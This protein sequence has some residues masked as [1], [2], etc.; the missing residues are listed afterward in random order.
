MSTFWHIMDVLENI[1]NTATVDNLL[2][3]WFIQSLYIQPELMTYMMVWCIYTEVQ[4]VVAP[5]RLM[6]RKDL[7]WQKLFGLIFLFEKDRILSVLTEI[8]WRQNFFQNRL[9]SEYPNYSMLKLFYHS[10]INSHIK[11]SKTLTSSTFMATFSKKLV[12]FRFMRQERKISFAGL[13]I[14]P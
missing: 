9:K 6:P 10:T 11:L 7:S 8:I 1:Y 3:V 12:E 2:D 4:K 13:Y 14:Q 5:R